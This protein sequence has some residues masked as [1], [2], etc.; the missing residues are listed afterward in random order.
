MKIEPA[1]PWTR[2]TTRGVGDLGLGREGLRPVQMALK[3]SSPHLRH[4]RAHEGRAV[5][6][7]PGLRVEA[8]QAP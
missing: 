8:E 6:V 2:E 1:Q 3:P 7:L 4:D 5:D